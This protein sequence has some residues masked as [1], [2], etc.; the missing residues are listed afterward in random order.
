MVRRKQLSSM[1]EIGNALR[2]TQCAVG[3]AEHSFGSKL[4]N[5]RHLVQIAQYPSASCL[6]E[7]RFA[8]LIAAPKA[9]IELPP[10]E[11]TNLVLNGKQLSAR[12]HRRAHSRCSSWV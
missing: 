10:D 1:K 7:R 12:P 2:R 8:E 6:A 5:N 3:L 9:T 11:G 4:H